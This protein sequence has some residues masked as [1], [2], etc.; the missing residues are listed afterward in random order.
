M[1]HF[2]CD[3]D[4][5]TLRETDNYIELSVRH[6]IGND[7]LNE[8]EK[9]K[10]KLELISVNNE[11]AVIRIY[12]TEIKE[13]LAYGINDI[14][15]IRCDV[16][17]YQYGLHIKFSSV[18]YKKCIKYLESAGLSHNRRRTKWWNQNLTEIQKCDIINKLMEFPYLK[19][20]EED[21]T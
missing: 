15:K 20:L 9:Y 5:A 13:A 19:V 18:P 6:E 11:W 2:G 7:L 12:D 1:Y 21:A 14:L 17:K 4:V 10:D 16:S 3:N 8:L